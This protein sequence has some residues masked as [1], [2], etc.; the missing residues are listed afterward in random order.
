MQ[1]SIEERVDFADGREFAWW[2]EYA[3]LIV[4]SRLDWLAVWFVRW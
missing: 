3:M 4:R 2:R 1:K